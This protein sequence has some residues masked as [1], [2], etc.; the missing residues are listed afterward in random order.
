MKYGLKRQVSQ[1]KI[2]VFFLFLDYVSLPVDPKVKFFGIKNFP[3]K[4][5]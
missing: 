3:F 5:I 1:T 2:Y 4:F